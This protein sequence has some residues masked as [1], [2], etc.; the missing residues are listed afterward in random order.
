MTEEELDVLDLSALAWYWRKEHMRAKEDRLEVKNRLKVTAQGCVAALE[1]L[2]LNRHPEP[3][4]AIKVEEGDKY[5]A[6][7]TEDDEKERLMD[8]DVD[9][10]G[11]AMDED[12][13]QDIIIKSGGKGKA[14]AIVKDSDDDFRMDEDDDHE[15]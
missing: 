7:K 4:S 13:D 6:I 14:R 11:H 5:G 8:V 15:G 9:D 10:K 3:G 1:R 2:I 12:D